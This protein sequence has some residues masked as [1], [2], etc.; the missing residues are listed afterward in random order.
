MG[1]DQS[2]SGSVSIEI[3]G[4]ALC[5]EQNNN[6][7]SSSDQPR[8][9]CSGRFP[10]FTSPK[11]ISECLN[12]DKIMNKDLTND[13][14]SREDSVQVV[15]ANS[16]EENRCFGSSSENLASMNCNSNGQTN[17]GEVYQV[18][19]NEQYIENSA[20]MR[21][22]K[23]I[24]MGEVPLHPMGLSLSG[25]GMQLFVKM[26][27]GVQ[28]TIMQNC[29]TRNQGTPKKKSKLTKKSKKSTISTQTATMPMSLERPSTEFSDEQIGH[30]R[31]TQ[32]PEQFVRD[33]MLFIGEQSN[34]SNNRE[35]ETHYNT[36][37]YG[38]RF[39]YS[40]TF[41][42]QSYEKQ[43]KNSSHLRTYVCVNEN[44][45]AQS[46]YA[47]AERI[48]NYDNYSN[49]FAGNSSII[50]NLSKETQFE[51]N[52]TPNNCL[53]HDGLG[54][55]RLQNEGFTSYDL[56][57]KKKRISVAKKSESDIKQDIFAGESTSQGVCI[58][59][60]NM[61]HTSR[62]L[63]GQGAHFL[64]N[65]VN[66][67]EDEKI[68]EDYLQLAENDMRNDFSKRNLLTK[69]KLN[70]CNSCRKSEIAKRQLD[71]PNASN[72][73]EST[74]FPNFDIDRI[75]S[76][77]LDAETLEKFTEYTKNMR[78]DLRENFKNLSVLMKEFNNSI[79]ERNKNGQD[80]E[81]GSDITRSNI[82][83]SEKNSDGKVCSIM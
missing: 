28:K 43:D 16:N 18:S 53:N 60:D 45:S 48:E 77:T 14:V 70:E 55:K 11:E 42:R 68:G 76:N 51:Q 73:E 49:K 59:R 3:T 26:D 65:P 38:K 78:K 41:P 74:G 63:E 69:S 7:M 6:L 39:C 58:I 25:S 79:I 29:M 35:S 8:T 37:L 61:A 47:N 82:E 52:H 22:I 54:N 30:S 71:V 33:N 36:K 32:L 80:E 15:C 10:D 23:H 62:A 75:P 21:K 19:N 50:V 13:E 83:K 72:S 2:I 44:E 31:E 64:T 12:S 17:S 46:F 56:P 20:F 24:N 67:H 1:R 27:D 9:T 66:F 5:S 57:L 40:P 81:S 4:S 34:Y